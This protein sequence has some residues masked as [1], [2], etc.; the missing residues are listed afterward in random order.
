MKV[1]WLNHRDIEHPSAGGAE[2]TI[3][4]VS[5]RLVKRGHDVTLISSA[6]PGANRRACHSGVKVERYPSYLGPH[7]VLPLVLRS[8]VRP[9]VVVDDLAHVLPWGSPL[10]A[11]CRGTVFFRHLHARTL[12]G[13][14]T[15]LLAKLL[16]RVERSYH[17]IYRN[18]TFTT[19]ARGT[20]RDL[21]SIGIDANRCKLIP[22]GVDTEL[23]VP[24][25][26]GL[27]PELVY[28]GGMRA[29]KRPSHAVKALGLL[30]SLGITA[31]LTVVGD[32]P[33][34][35][36][37]RELAKQLGVSPQVK[38]A[39]HVS[40]SRLA[41][42]LSTAWV[43][44]HCSTSEGWGYSTLEAAS[45]GVPTVAY[46]VSGIIDSVADGVSGKLVCDGQPSALAAGIKEVIESFPSWVTKCREHALRFK[47]EKCSRSWEDHLREVANNY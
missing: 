5:K 35:S 40:T 9:D 27:I 39:G 32:G 24:G 37:V 26:K 2:R 34:S 11:A 1:L 30:K 41:A 33:E 6:W 18:W 28:F 14:V 17:L 12:E 29:Y 23:F 3:H 4:E 7:L 20:L 16:V 21:Q 8:G 45:A 46:A 25:N 47:W 22:P 44:I 31:Q 43:N 38:F 19:E 10:L 36:S 42:L 13:Q 15:P